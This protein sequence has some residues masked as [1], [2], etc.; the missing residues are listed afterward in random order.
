MAAAVVSTKSIGRSARFIAVAMLLWPAASFSQNFTSTIDLGSGRAPAQA[1]GIAEKVVRDAFGGNRAYRLQ[2]R[3]NVPFRERISTGSAS[4]AEFRF[5]D[6]TSLSVGENAELDLDEFVYDPNQNVL[7]G[8]MN[9][10]KG[11]MRFVGS[12]ARKQVAIETPNG[13]MG[14]R[15]TS[16]NLR[17]APGV[18]ELEV[19]SGEVQISSAGSQ[20]TVRANQFVQISGGTIRQMAPTP[21]FRAAVSQIAATLGAPTLAATAPAPASAGL[22][23]VRAADGRLL[24]YTLTRTDGRV[25][26]LDPGRRLI[27]YFDPASNATYASNGRSL[28]LGNRVPALARGDSR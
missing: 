14:I 12:K 17:A 16:F 22:A 21:V 27:A 18:T 28:G 3:Q 23:E 1:I 26:A 20:Q 24:G 13:S 6:G 4:G 8:A 5:L 7:R 19:V 15:G 10:T 25:D 2:I 11:V 9:L